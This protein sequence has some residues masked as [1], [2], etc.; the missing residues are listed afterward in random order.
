MPTEV[1]AVVVVVVAVVVLVVVRVVIWLAT[2]GGGGETSRGA[3][4]NTSKKDSG[5]EKSDKMHVTTGAY[6]TVGRP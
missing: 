3:I 4:A 1:V 6:T 2:D 5:S